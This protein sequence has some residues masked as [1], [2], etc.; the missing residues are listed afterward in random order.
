MYLSKNLREPLVAALDLNPVGG[1]DVRM[2]LPVP[3]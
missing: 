3:W 2:E 1:V